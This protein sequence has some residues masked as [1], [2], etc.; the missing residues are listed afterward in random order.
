MRI[1]TEIIES[2][3]QGWET[4]DQSIYEMN[5]LETLLDI[6]DLLANPPIEISGIEIDPPEITQT[7]Q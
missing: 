5:V 2:Q 7:K 3:I 1:R 6:R 4:H